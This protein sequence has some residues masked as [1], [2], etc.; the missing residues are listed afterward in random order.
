MLS[1]HTQPTY[2]EEQIR[3][4]ALWVDLMKE[5]LDD[6]HDTYNVRPLECYTKNL[7][8]SNSPKFFALVSETAKFIKTLF[9]RALASHSVPIE[10]SATFDSNGL[11]SFTT[12][13]FGILPSYLFPL[14][15]SK[16][17][18]V[19]V[20]CV[21]KN[22]VQNGKEYRSYI[23]KQCG[24]IVHQL[25]LMPL[26]HQIKLGKLYKSELMEICRSLHL[27][28]KGKK[29]ELKKN[30]KDYIKSQSSTRVILNAPSCVGCDENHSSPTLRKFC[31]GCHDFIAENHE[32]TT[33]LSCG[34]LIHNRCIPVNNTC[35]IC[36]SLVTEMVNEICFRAKKTF[37]TKSTSPT[38]PCNND[39][40]ACDKDDE[41][42]EDREEVEGNRKKDIHMSTYLGE[43]AT[44]VKKKKEQRG[45][46]PKIK[47]SKVED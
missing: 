20:C 26:V 46:L 43:L 28:A 14:A 39:G 10:E 4:T 23:R 22:L 31:H 12:D 8:P 35:V 16:P 3:K 21:C 40:G 1:G 42:H 47:I 45:S 11:L 18:C 30:I 15:C 24:H 19:A 36:S 7:T 13:A 41:E 2:T 33:R 38:Q 5:Q 9:E 27:N 32:H 6:I 37:S 44:K 34:H 25:C 29:D 17:S